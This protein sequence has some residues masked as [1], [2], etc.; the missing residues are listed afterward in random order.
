MSSLAKYKVV[1]F[2]WY[3]K[4]V[5]MI[6]LKSH[7]TK[8]LLKKSAFTIFSVLLIFNLSNFKNSLLTRRLNLKTEI[9]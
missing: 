7:Q 8:I 5:L 2:T 3:N 9:S 4:F 1:F 6:K